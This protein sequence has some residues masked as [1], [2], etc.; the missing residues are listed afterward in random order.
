MPALFNARMAGAQAEPLS[1]SPESGANTEPTPAPRASQRPPNDPGSELAGIPLAAQDLGWKL[2]GT[3]VAD[4]PATRFAVI[5]YQSTGNQRAYREGAHL[6]E[7]LI[8]TILDGQV[9]IS[10]GTG[11]AVL[12]ML[13]GRNADALPLPPRIAYLPREEVDSTLP[14]EMQFMREIGVRPQF[15]GGRP[16]GFVIYSIQAE[17]I[18]ARMGLQDGDVI[19][20]VN[21]KSFATTQTTMEFYDALKKGG[22]ISLEIKRE[23]STQRLFFEIW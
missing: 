15:E 17:S 11:D 13:H 1:K 23:D 18:F 10:T 7:H 16:S 21:G 3:A 22:T 14:D 5:E 2:V 9:L 4:D 6:G 19:V 8:K 20:G 12:S